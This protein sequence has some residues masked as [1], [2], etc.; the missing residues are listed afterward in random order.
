MKRSRGSLNGMLLLDTL[1]LFLGNVCLPL[2]D[3]PR[4]RTSSHKHRSSQSSTPSSGS[5][6]K[7]FRSE[8]RECND[9]R[10]HA[11]LIDHRVANVVR[12]VKTYDTRDSGPG[13][14]CSSAKWCHWAC[15]ILSSLGIDSCRGARIYFS[16]SL[17]RDV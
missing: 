12:S 11:H 4:Q 5:K 14:K 8:V 3:H 16:C 13:S 1:F 15:L 9:K 17:Q 6:D 10:P 7:P 2:H